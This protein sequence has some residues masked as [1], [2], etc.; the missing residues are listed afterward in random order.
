VKAREWAPVF[1]EALLVALAEG[2]VLL[3]GWL[4]KKLYRWH[5]RRRRR[6]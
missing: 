5:K 3:G 2:L 6:R 1:V 4:L